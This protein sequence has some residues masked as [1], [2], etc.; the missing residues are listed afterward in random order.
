LEITCNFELVEEWYPFMK[1]EETKK[2]GRYDTTNLPVKGLG[3]DKWALVANILLDE[4]MEK[5]LDMGMTEEEI[6]EGCITHL[7]KPPTKRSRKP[8]YGM[9]KCRYF[10]VIGDKKISASLI[11]TERNSKHFWGR[12]S[13]STPGRKVSK[14]GRPRKTR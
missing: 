7:N 4:A 9:L 12:G 3:Y 13:K 1:S 2:S 14:R 10:N 6:V 8:K 5:Y 11:T